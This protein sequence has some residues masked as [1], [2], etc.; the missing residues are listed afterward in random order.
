[1]EAYAEAKA[2]I[3]A[4]AP[5]DA[6]LAYNVDDPI[7]S[8]LAARAPCRTVPCSGTRRPEHGNGVDGDT[9][10]IDTHRYDV[11]HVDDT[12]RFNLV[13]AGTLAF[14]MGADADG[15]GEVI[16]GFRPGPHRRELV[17]TIGGVAYVNDS[18]ATNPHAALAA[19]AAYPSVVLLAGGRNK[20]LD[21]APLATAEPVKAL[22]AFGESASAIADL[23]PGEVTVASNLAEAFADAVAIAEPGDTVLLSPGCASF[24][25]FT[26]YEARGVAFRDLVGRLKEPAA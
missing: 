20:G 21:L 8:S 18:K 22:I 5:P 25:E 3:F 13:V 19:V 7:V 24:D 14:A 17:A 10:V 2:T 23:A 16:A 9:L 26:S 15:V 12:Y 4:D 6:L 11:R 1:M